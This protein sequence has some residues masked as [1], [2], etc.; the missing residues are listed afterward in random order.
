MTTYNVQPLRDKTEIDDFLFWLRRTSNPKRDV[1]LFVFGIN[2]G[3]R[4]SDIVK[5]KVGDIRGNVNPIIVE[6]KT[7]K[8]RQLFL[9]PLQEQIQEYTKGMAD[10]DWLFPSRNGQGSNHIQVQ[11]VYKLYDKVAKQLGRGDIGTH[12]IRKTFG[13]HYYRKTHDIAMLMY[14]FNHSSESVT[15]RYIGITQDEIGNSLEGFKIGF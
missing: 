1:F 11:T 6:K 5:L 3:L 8:K 14:I 10:S 4:M 13:Y 9:G 12:T 7:G 2:T 15:K